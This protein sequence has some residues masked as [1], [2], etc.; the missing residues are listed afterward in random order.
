MTDRRSAQPLDVAV[1]ML[2]NSGMGGAERRFAQV[3][4]HLR[5]RHMRVA[6][7]LN[8]SLAHRLT[9]CDLSD[10]EDEAEVV[11]LKEPI[12]RLLQRFAPS[13]C[14]PAHALEGSV[15][16]CRRLR[17]FLG[18]LDYL[19]ATVRVT[20][21]VLRRRP[22]IMHLVLG[23][24][25]VALPMQALGLGPPAIISVTNPNLPD[26]VGTAMAVPLYR[27]ALRNARVVDALTDDIA[28]RLLAEGVSPRQLSV[29]RGSCVNTDRFQPAAAKQPWI[30]F[31]GRLIP[32]K[33]PELFVESCALVHKEVEGRIAGVRFFLFGEGPL[34]ASLEASAERHGLMPHMQIGWCDRV[35]SILAASLVFLSLQ[36]TDNYPSQ[37]LLEAMASG[38]AVVATDVG[39]TW[40]LVDDRVGRRVKP[41]TDAV[42]RAVVDL[43]GTPART[44]T[45]GQHA[46]DRVMQQHSMNAYLDYLECLY[47]KVS[48]PHGQ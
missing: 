9:A 13:G 25:Y 36:R 43:L 40:K 11:V 12:G 8:E 4:D 31:S 39:L 19:L 22:R 18:K 10:T 35:E 2:N 7:V 33:N 16:P 1:I 6:L 38:M 3:V 30:V 45:L 28:G 17:F 34:R 15:G 32:E 42:A 23:G 46:R 37:A 47:Q 26:M 5:H 14:S 27:Q 48:T 20:L 41:S 44:E 29:S 24:A 21:W